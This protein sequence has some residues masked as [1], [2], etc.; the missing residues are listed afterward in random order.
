RWR[1]ASEMERPAYFSGK[2]VSFHT[3][4]PFTPTSVRKILNDV[5]KQPGV[6]KPSSDSIVILSNALNDTCG[7]FKFSSEI[8]KKSNATAA[9]VFASFE[10]LR[11]FFSERKHIC[12]RQMNTLPTQ[13]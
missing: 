12:E 4:G 13:I 3:G 11:L 5:L 10:T 1:G 6:K 2:H 8:A 7:A 9:R